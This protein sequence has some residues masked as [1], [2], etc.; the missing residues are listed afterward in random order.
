MEYGATIDL[1]HPMITE[2]RDDEIEKVL[3]KGKKAGVPID[4]EVDESSVTQ[5]YQ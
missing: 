3:R 5:D 4:I 2:R 1:G